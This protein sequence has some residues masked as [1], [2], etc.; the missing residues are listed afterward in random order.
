MQALLWVGVWL[1]LGVA[2]RCAELAVATGSQLPD[3]LVGANYQAALEAQGG[4]GPYVWTAPSNGLPAGLVLAGE[5][6]ISGTPV[7][8]CTNAFRL[9][10]TDQAGAAAEADFF[11]CVTQATTGGNI[12]FNNGANQIFDVDGITPLAN[13]DFAARLYVG[14]SPETLA[15]LGGAAYFSTM[16]PGSFLGGTVFVPWAAPGSSVWVELRVMETKGGLTWEAAGASGSK[17]WA[18]NPKLLTLGGSLPGMPPAMPAPL[19]ALDFQYLGPTNL[20]IRTQPA[21]LTT[22]G[23]KTAV[24]TVDVIGAPRVKYQWQFNGA[25]LGGATNRTFAIAYV[26]PKDFG[27]YRVV[28][29][30]PYESMTSAV[31]VV[32]AQLAPSIYVQPAPQLIRP[33]ESGSLSVAASGELPMAYQWWFNGAPIAGANE[34]SLNLTNM[35]A[36]RVGNYWAVLTNAYGSAT[37]RVAQVNL[38]LPP[39]IVSGPQDAFGNLGYS[40]NLEVVAAG[41]PPFS[42]QWYKDGQAL[43]GSTQAIL[44][45]SRALTNDTGKY[46]VTVS[47]AVGA[48]TSQEAVL[49]PYNWSTWINTGNKYEYG[50]AVVKPGQARTFSVYFNGLGGASYQWFK[51]DTAMT[52]CTNAKLALMN[53]Q[54]EDAGRYSVQAW[55]D[56]VNL[57]RLS[58][59]L[60]VERPLKILAPPED[61]V[62]VIGA[63]ARFEVRATNDD[64]A[65]YQWYFNGKPLE[66]DGHYDGTWTSQLHIFGVKESD[67]GQYSV[68][69]SNLLGSTDNLTATLTVCPPDFVGRNTNAIIIH[70]KGAAS[71]YPAEIVVPP[72]ARVAAV[73]VTVSNLS[74]SFPSDV[75]LLLVGPNG[76]KVLLMGAAGG[77]WG[78]SNVTMT[79]SDAAPG[80]PP[81]GQAL[82][83][84]T[85]APTNYGPNS[86]AW[87]PGFPPP[88]PTPPYDTRL[89]AFQG[90]DSVGTW[91][92]YVLDTSKGDGGVIADG[93]QLKLRQ[94]GNVGGLAQP[95][96]VTTPT[97]FSHF[98]FSI[99]SSAATNWPQ[100]MVVLHSKQPENIGKYFNIQISTNLIHWSTISTVLNEEGIISYSE[101]GPPCDRTRFYR[102]ILA[103]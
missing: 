49:Y 86:L 68:K 39:T 58:V 17:R 1:G 7:M 12:W 4:T 33:G 96:L 14:S 89:S 93:W 62:G 78:V 6:L 36:E 103:P 27:D 28:V 40:V 31:A 44:S 13:H 53:I 99:G 61:T 46:K 57:G 82:F 41:T 34:A 90:M 21:G 52:G 59:D 102:A 63:I 91:S 47:N 79:F 98:V 48:A 15:P 38:L 22:G 24:L 101:P 19:P 95:I 43:L 87:G 75:D 9:R 71:L 83:A 64:Y 42:Y 65:E 3:A 25:D 60:F 73:E 69:L 54:V 100:P 92:L 51:D 67:A 11:L 26:T 81:S 76:R 88:A 97:D 32:T 16:S 84:G 37:S 29:S 72:L 18:S 35:S 10:V 85:F 74:H 30:N 56:Y 66:D 70:E 55:N 45:F 77:R 23:G 50:L 20:S 2:G 80:V 5:G 8:L 94:M